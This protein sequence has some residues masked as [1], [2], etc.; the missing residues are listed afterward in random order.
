[1]HIDEIFAYKIHITYIVNF[2]TFI[3]DIM[4]SFTEF[5]CKILIFLVY[6][7]NETCK[8]HEIP[9]FSYINKHKITCNT[10]KCLLVQFNS[11]FV[12]FRNIREIS[13]EQNTKNNLRM[14]AKIT[15]KV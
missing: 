7:K 12:A 8:I 2:N 15:S 11:A 13:R 3:E 6:D 5:L 4:F 10:F 14:V 1:M 9:N